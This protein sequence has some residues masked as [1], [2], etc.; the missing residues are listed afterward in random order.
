ML[1]RL[2][3]FVPT[4]STSC[5]EFASQFGLAIFLYPKNTQ[6]Y[7]EDRV[8][9]VLLL[10]FLKIIYTIIL[11]QSVC[12]LFAICMS[13]FLLDRLG[14]CLKLFLSDE[15]TSCHEFASQ[16]SLEIFLHAKNTQN[17]REYRVAR[18][19]VYLNEAAT[20]HWSP[21]EPAKRGVN[22][23]KVGRHRSIEQRQPER[24]WQWAG[25]SV[26]VMCLQYIFDPG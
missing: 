13:Q 10:V 3:L 26:R 12:S 6:N 9:Y 7:R 22:S 19:T 15:S 5:H 17:Y 20:G 24:R 2:K 21:A 23:V 16:F 8:S 4:E 11:L 25:A 1:D 14:R 18:V